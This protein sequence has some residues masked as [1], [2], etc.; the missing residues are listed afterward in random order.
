M[1]ETCGCNTIKAVLRQSKYRTGEIEIVYKDPKFDVYS[2]EYGD[3][4]WGTSIDL[5]EGDNLE[6]AIKEYGEKAI[7]DA[8]AGE[9]V[10]VCVPFSEITPKYSIL[11]KKGDMVIPSERDLSSMCFEGVITLPDGRQVEPDH[12]DSPLSKMG[13]I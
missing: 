9:E 7:T 3:G 13:L 2:Y 11:N 1:A 12:P 10:P 6:K 4:I 5:L 8:E